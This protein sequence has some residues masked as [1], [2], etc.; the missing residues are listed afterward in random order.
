MNRI[1]AAIVMLLAVGQAGAQY[2][3]AGEVFAAANAGPGP[4]FVNA[5]GY[6]TGLVDAGYG[7]LICPP[8]G[9]SAATVMGVA[10]RGMRSAAKSINDPAAPVIIKALVAAYPCRPA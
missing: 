5:L 10:V 4:E 1:L 8:P 7:F 3:T 9:T 2:K 6:I